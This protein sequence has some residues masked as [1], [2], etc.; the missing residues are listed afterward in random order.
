M[1]KR[2]INLLIISIFVAILGTYVLF[3][4]IEQTSFSKVINK[5]NYVKCYLS[6]YDPKINSVLI[7]SKKDVHD[8]FKNLED[9][10][11]RRLI[12]NKKKSY[13]TYYSIS[14]QENWILIYDNKYV[15]ITVG[16]N[17]KWYKLVNP[18]NPIIFEK[19][20]VDES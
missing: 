10:K 11:V 18:I 12:I 2:K 19:Y 6:K 16:D 7:T 4:W 17:T 1:R 9:K 3:H 20:F 14:T 15:E 8:I 5:E 13:K